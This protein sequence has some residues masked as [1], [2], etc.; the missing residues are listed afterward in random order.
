[1][2]EYVIGFKKLSRAVLISLVLPSCT[3][4]AECV[5]ST[6]G[7]DSME[8]TNITVDLS[9]TQS[10]DFTMLIADGNDERAAGFQHVCPDVI[11]STLILFVFP[12]DYD[13]AFHMRNVHEPLDI[14]FLDSSGMIVDIQT[15]ATYFLGARENPLYSP[16][17]PVRAALEAHVGFFEEQ[18]FVPGV[19][20]IRLPG[21]E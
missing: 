7:I 2:R 21:I 10:R 18:G 4:A 11:S 14:A 12:R 3:H 19:T 8:L 1:M 20:R 9:A 13:A 6:P 17:L 5:Q 16:P 15:M